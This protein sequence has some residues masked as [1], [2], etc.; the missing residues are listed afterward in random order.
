MPLLI[1]IKQENKTNKQ[2]NNIPARAQEARILSLT[3]SNYNWNALL[4]E[5]VFWTGCSSC[6]GVTCPWCS[7]SASWGSCINFCSRPR[8]WI[9]GH[10]NQ[11]WVYMC[12]PSWPSLPR[13]S[14]SNLLGSSQCTSSEPP[15]S[16]I[17][18]GLAIYYTYDNIH[19]SMLF[20]QIISPSP[21]PIES[22]SLFFTSVFL[23]QPR[24]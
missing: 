6:R 17:E 13:P 18:P 4:R 24:I 11:P 5:R 1:K 14:P 7:S 9:R 22:N 15:A 21:S 10:M 19:I 16:C 3:K 20:S 23:L 12:F 8:G 2:T